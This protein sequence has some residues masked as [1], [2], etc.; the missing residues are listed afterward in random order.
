MA[1][2]RFLMNEFHSV[3]L[4]QFALLIIKLLIG[5]WG[6]AVYLKSISKF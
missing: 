2:T 1:K 5:V 4:T 6:F 3:L